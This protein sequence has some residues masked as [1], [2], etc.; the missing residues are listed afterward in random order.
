MV[1]LH[2][3]R[4]AA[5]L[6]T[7]LLQEAERV[8]S[9]RLVMDQITADLRCARNESGAR[10]GLSGDSTSLRLVKAAVP[11]LSAWRAGQAGVVA[12]ESDL[13]S[14]AYSLS[15]AISGTNRVVNGLV[16][17][18]ESSVENRQSVEVA[19]RGQGPAEK[20]PSAAPA[21]EPLSEAI[22]YIRFRYWDGS[23]WRETWGASS[24]PVGVEVTLASEPPTEATEPGQQSG[25][26][27]RRVVYLP[28]NSGD[29]ESADGSRK[30]DSLS[31][32]EEVG[33]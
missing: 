18:E 27:F 6:R 29:P 1:M 23:S 10:L 22:G 5:D 33:P 31:P 21:P 7:Q 13:R 25:E 9:I 16:R 32:S 24:L 2:F 4:Q 30:T 19:R 14:V 17:T 3:Y 8:S 12:L 28:G 11:S 20:E 15:T 26:I